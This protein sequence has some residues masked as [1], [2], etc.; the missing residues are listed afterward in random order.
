[1]DKERE[2]KITVQIYPKKIS[3]A[4]L[5]TVK[6]STMDIYPV[7]MSSVEISTE[8]LCN[9]FCN[10]IQISKSCCSGHQSVYLNNTTNITKMHKES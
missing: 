10:L 5:S 1:M 7:E 6:T 2:E 4:S 3:R 9:N 8:D